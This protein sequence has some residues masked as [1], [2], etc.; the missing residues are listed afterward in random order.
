MLP[1]VPD[2][3]VISIYLPFLHGREIQSARWEGIRIPHNKPQPPG[4]VKQNNTKHT[5]T[6]EAISVNCVGRGTFFFE[7]V[8]WVLLPML[9][10]P[11]L[12]G[13]TGKLNS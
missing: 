8:C 4:L 1:S 13:D 9:A 5:E 11:D 3:S 10:S 2:D 7:R 12:L 6:K